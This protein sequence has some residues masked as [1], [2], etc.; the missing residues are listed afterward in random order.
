MKFLQIRYQS[1][2]SLITF[3]VQEHCCKSAPASRL[4]ISAFSFRGE[5][6]LIY[7]INSE[8]IPIRR[9]HLVNEAVIW[10]LLF[11]QSVGNS[12]PHITTAGSALAAWTCHLTLPRHFR[13][14][15]NH[16]RRVEDWHRYRIL[17]GRLTRVAKTSSCRDYLGTASCSSFFLSWLKSVFHLWNPL[18][19]AVCLL[20]HLLI[21]S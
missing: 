19:K 11:R 8:R 9:D 1:A 4:L 6:H 10:V 7:I 18:S 15:N 17:W 13:T 14:L 21:F 12:G 5:S 3:W 2:P 20:I 16:L